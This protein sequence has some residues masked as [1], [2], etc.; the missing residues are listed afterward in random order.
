MA[1][2]TGF[3]I[4]WSIHSPGT[5]D[6]RARFLSLARSKLRLCLANHR[7]GYFSNLACDWLSIVW[8][9]SEQETKNGPWCIMGSRDQWEFP[10]VFRPYWQ[11]PCTVL[12][13][14]NLPAIRLCKGTVKESI[15][16]AAG[17]R[18]R[19]QQLHY[20]PSLPVISNALVLLPNGL[21]WCNPNKAISQVHCISWRPLIQ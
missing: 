15:I 20:W 6:I 21:N 9:Y 17:G 4:G 5:T 2:F 11:S 12:M 1:C 3:V 19:H 16:M 7:A 8:A 10:P 14:G 13:A 18:Q